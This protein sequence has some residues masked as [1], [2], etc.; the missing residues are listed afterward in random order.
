MSIQLFTIILPR[1]NEAVADRIRDQYSE[2][3]EVSDTLF[4][5]ATDSLTN[6]IAEAI[7]VKGENRIED[8]S[9]V[10]FKLNGAYSGYAA[11]SLWEWLEKVEDDIGQG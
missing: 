1:K 5:V 8:S 2:Y 11:R 9:A 3:F 4:L 6:I 7:G 10:I